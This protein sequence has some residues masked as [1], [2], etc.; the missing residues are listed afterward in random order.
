MDFVKLGIP[1]RN[2]PVVNAMIRKVEESTDS[3]S[4][5]NQDEAK[6]LVETLDKVRAFHRIPLPALNPRR[7]GHI[8]RAS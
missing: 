2:I 8:F 6:E 7:L 4:P 3:S 1:P 5:L